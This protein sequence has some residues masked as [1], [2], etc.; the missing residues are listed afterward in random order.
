MKVF[1]PLLVALFAAT[2]CSPKKE[3]A[4]SVIQ[5]IPAA[6]VRMIEIKANESSGTLKLRLSLGSDRVST[7]GKVEDMQIVVVEN[8]GGKCGIYIRQGGTTDKREIDVPESKPGVSR[9]FS[10]R[11]SVPTV[12]DVLAGRGDVLKLEWIKGGDPSDKAAVLESVT[13]SLVFE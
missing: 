6:G 12:E 3:P 2:A 13:F 8:L 9:G 7:W 5:S 10:V 1:P 4:A 11:K